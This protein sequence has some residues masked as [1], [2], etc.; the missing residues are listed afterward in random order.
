MS[1]F[2]RALSAFTYLALLT[3]LPV[4]FDSPASAVAPQSTIYLTAW[5]NN[6]IDYTAPDGYVIDHIDFAS[7][8]TPENYQLGWCHAADSQ[9]IV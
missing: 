7:Y 8:G 1:K 6:S 3:F 5:E 2:I 4:A 9:S